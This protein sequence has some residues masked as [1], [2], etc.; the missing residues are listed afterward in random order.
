[1]IYMMNEKQILEGFKTKD[2]EIASVL[3]ATGQIINSTS[4]ENGA[5]YFLYENKS[6]CDEIVANYFRGQIKLNAKVVWDAIK[7]IKGIIYRR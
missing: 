2:Q 5:C 3:Y 7:T 1:M 6:Q 4:W